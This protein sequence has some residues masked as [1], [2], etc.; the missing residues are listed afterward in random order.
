[1]DSKEVRDEPGFIADQ[2][3]SL[4]NYRGLVGWYALPPDAMRC[5]AVAPGKSHLCRTKHGRGWVAR[6]EGG[7]LSVIGRDCAQNTFA[8]DSSIMADIHRA[9]A[10]I[11]RDEQLARLAG[12][13][14]QRETRMQEQQAALVGL[15]ERRK[16]L[17]ELLQEVGDATRRAIEDRARTGRGTVDVTG[18]VPAKRDSDGE[19]IREAVAVP[20]RVGT[21]PEIRACNPDTMRQVGDALRGLRKAYQAAS[22]EATEESTGAQRKLVA[23]LN[24]HDRVVGDAIALARQLDAFLSSDLRPLAFL[25]HGQRDRA[26]AA[27]AALSRQGL[28]DGPK[29]WIQRAEAEL[30]RAHSVSKIRIE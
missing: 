23:A 4:D 21:L 24:D 1:M 5:C 18:T 15:E 3:V 27:R 22:P 28:A 17:S 10:Q 11:D 6:V 8:A 2:P 9:T 12:L 13:L 30:C 25:V 29:Q 14:A 20:I 19:V 7:A 26:D 16:R